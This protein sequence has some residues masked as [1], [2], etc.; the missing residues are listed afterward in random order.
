MVRLL[1]VFW[2]LFIIAV[3]L[4][5]VLR[6]G[7]GWILICSRLSMLLYWILSLSSIINL[8]C[9]GIVDEVDNLLLN[10]TGLDMPAFLNAAI[11]NLVTLGRFPV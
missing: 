8:G 4:G 7:D 2:F 3:A 1:G 11:I 5:D 9:L 6:K 10:R